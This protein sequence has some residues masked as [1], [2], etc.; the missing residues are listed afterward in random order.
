[1]TVLDLNQA[2]ELAASEARYWA[3]LEVTL[4]RVFSTEPGVAERYRRG[5]IDASPLQRALALHDH[6]LDVAAS[7]TGMPLTADRVALYDDMISASARPERIVRHV[8]ATGTQPEGILS[9]ARR[10]MS[11]PMVTVM[12][13]NKL[14]GELGYHRLTISSGVAHL[15]L[16]RK[17]WKRPLPKRLDMETLPG[18]TADREEVYG[19]DRVLNVLSGLQE[20]ARRRK[21]ASSII[22]RIEK[23]KAR[24]LKAHP[25]AP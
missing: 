7:L 16:E 1:M 21:S 23:M 13:L 18:L 4:R 2:E 20:F 15:Q 3:D 8:P 6:A 19:L 9:S 12:T 14:M 10:D 17:A 22:T 5:L 24:L 25:S 11:A